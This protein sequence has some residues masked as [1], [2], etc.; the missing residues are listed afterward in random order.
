MYSAGGSQSLVPSARF[1]G[2]FAFTNGVV[3]LVYSD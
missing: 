2:L 1:S 3:A